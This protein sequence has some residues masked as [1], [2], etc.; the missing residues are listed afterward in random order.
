MNKLNEIYLLCNNQL[1]LIS[2]QTKKKPQIRSK[3]FLEMLK[4]VKRYFAW[5]VRNYS[6]IIMR[7]NH[8]REIRT[9]KIKRN[10]FVFFFLKRTAGVIR[11]EKKINLKINRIFFRFNFFF[12]VFLSFWYSVRSEHKLNQNYRLFLCEF[13]SQ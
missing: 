4:S 5:N 12:V 3:I 8:F 11:K 10:T 13:R 2:K 1:L 6:N 7:K 9:E